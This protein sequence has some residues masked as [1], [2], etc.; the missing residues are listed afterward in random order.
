VGSGNW[1][2]GGRGELCLLLTIS[3][4]LLADF[5]WGGGVGENLGIIYKQEHSY[6]VCLVRSSFHASSTRLPT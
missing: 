3:F 6:L 4:F 2:V 5:G 1:G